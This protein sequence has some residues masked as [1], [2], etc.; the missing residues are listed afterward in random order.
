MLLLFLQQFLPDY[1]QFPE[2]SSGKLHKTFKIE[3]R[4]LNVEITS[5]WS[6]I[7]DEE[8]FELMKSWINN[9]DKE[10]PRPDVLILGII[11]LFFIDIV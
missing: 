2:Y 6:P 10:K 1:E 9:D 4:L 3:L 8:F 11:T 5:Y 7:F